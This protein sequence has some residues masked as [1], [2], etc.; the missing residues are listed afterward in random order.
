[1]TYTLQFSRSITEVISHQNDH[2][3]TKCEYVKNVTALKMKIICNEFFNFLSYIQITRVSFCNSHPIS[4]LLQAHTTAKT[5][6]TQAYTILEA[7]GKILPSTNDM[8]HVSC[9][10]GCAKILFFQL[11]VFLKF[12]RFDINLYNLWIG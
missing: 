8:D 12:V 1:M 2:V 3:Y 5:S 4:K 7:G 10:Q 11:I 9:H 6:S